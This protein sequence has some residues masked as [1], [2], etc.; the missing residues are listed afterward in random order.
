MG[1]EYLTNVPL[2]QAQEDYLS[3]LQAAGFAGDVET[4]PFLYRKPAV[5]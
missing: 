3:A 4:K 1:F 5:E 2:A